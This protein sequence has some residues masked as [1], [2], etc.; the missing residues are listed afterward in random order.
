MYK[1]DIFDGIIK[2]LV[3]HSNLKNGLT[4]T[5]LYKQLAEVLGR[6]VSHRDYSSHLSL[7]VLDGLLATEKG[8]ENKIL[9]RYFLTE[10]ARKMYQLKILGIGS[11]Y[12]K[13]LS[14][15]QLLIYYETFKRG[16]VLTDAQLSRV[17]KRYGI[18]RKNLKKVDAIQ[19]DGLDVQTAYEE[20]V[21]EIEIIQYPAGRF[22]TKSLKPVYYVLK[23]GLSVNEFLSYL[24]KLKNGKEPRPFSPLPGLVP[25][26]HFTSYNA[27]EV[28]DAISLLNDLNL[29]KRIAPALNKGDTRFRIADERLIKLIQ[30]IHLIEKVYFHKTLMKVV[31]I[32]PPDTDEKDIFAYY[33]GKKRVG[34][35]IAYLNSKRTHFFKTLNEDQLQEKREYVMKL[36]ND[37]EELTLASI[38][39][40]QEIVKD[41]FLKELYLPFSSYTHADTV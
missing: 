5:V 14:L 38:N 8:E 36:C 32:G 24:R 2:N 33:F 10:K 17:L 41:E 39:E 28:E 16:Q 20:P 19:F 25:F 40:N 6:K 27:R 34:H 7:M 37:I 3:Y 22:G 9:K 1:P 15:Y 23:R 31:F 12:E 35:V 29:L 21:N 11:E 13:R 26:V 18:R 4:Y 30:Q